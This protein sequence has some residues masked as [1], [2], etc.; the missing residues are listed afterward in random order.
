MPQG[1]LA[2]RPHPRSSEG[3]VHQSVRSQIHDSLSFA[4]DAVLS[5]SLLS[6]SRVD[7]YTNALSTFV[8]AINAN[9]SLHLELAPRLGSKTAKSRSIRISTGR[10]FVAIRQCQIASRTCCANAR[11]L[12]RFRHVVG[13][14]EIRTLIRASALQ[15]HY[16]MDR[17]W[18]SK[19]RLI[20][21]ICESQ[22][23]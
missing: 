12:E 14:T 7:A 8:G 20:V 22:S 18:R 11:D 9:S 4:Q 17:N 19:I 23:P 5:L 1:P 2:A 21:G 16:S 10:D 13:N 3:P 6:T 15:H